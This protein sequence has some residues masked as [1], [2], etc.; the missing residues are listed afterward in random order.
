MPHSVPGLM[1]PGII[2]PTGLTAAAAAAAAATNA[3]IAEA[4]KVKKIKLEVMS[5]YHGSNTQHGV[6]SENGDL[7]SSVGLE[8]P[9]IDDA[10]P[11]DPCQPA[12]CIVTMAMSR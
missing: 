2:P 11:P 3:A 8:L 5:S 7:S 6:D 12:S 4:M 1:S 10:P 9:F